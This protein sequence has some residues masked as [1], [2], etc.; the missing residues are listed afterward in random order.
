MKVGLQFFKVS[1]LKQTDHDSHCKDWKSM[2]VCVCVNVHL[3]GLDRMA[4][5]F[6]EDGQVISVQRGHFSL[7]K[8][9]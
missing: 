9:R 1:E 5:Y 8:L 2:R 4:E 3:Y 6:L 7:L